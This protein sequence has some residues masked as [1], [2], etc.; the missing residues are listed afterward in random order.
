MI[1]A[2]GRSFGMDVVFAMDLSSSSSK[3]S[4]EQQKSV[5]KSVAQYLLPSL[6][7]EL[8]LV[9]YSS[10]GL[11]KSGL[12]SAFN[13]DILD[14][15]DNAGGTQRVDSAVQ[16][17]SE[18]LFKPRN[19]NEKLRA[20]GKVFVL[21]V[22]GRQSSANPPSLSAESAKLLR[23]G[24]VRTVIIALDEMG[25]DFARNVPGAKLLQYSV[26]KTDK[27]VK[28]YLQGLLENGKS[29]FCF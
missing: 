17:A 4:L 13:S 22:S 2:E 20:R 1:S 16:V 5:V 3:E 21:F 6:S 28:S 12:S 11:V 29:L 25:Q 27:A 19:E 9:T 24:N 10:N 15:I 14:G 8:A 26:D 23:D 7:N 18:T